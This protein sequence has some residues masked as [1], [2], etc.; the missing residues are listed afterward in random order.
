MH[1]LL[2]ACLHAGMHT[3][4]CMCTYVYGH[5]VHVHT[6]SWLLSLLRASTSL[7]GFRGAGLGFGDDAEGLSGAPPLSLSVGTGGGGS[8]GGGGGGSTGGG[9]VLSDLNLDFGDGD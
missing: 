6:S 7:A 1:N 5:N 3:C 2:Y 8:T 9:E 4:T